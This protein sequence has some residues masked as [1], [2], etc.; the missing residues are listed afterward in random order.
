MQKWYEVIFS[1]KN[2]TIASLTMIAV[3]VVF[4][5]PISQIAQT[6]I[7]SVVSGLS[8]FTMGTILKKK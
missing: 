2:L 8:G 3:S 1:E 6:I 5:P 4:A 7:V